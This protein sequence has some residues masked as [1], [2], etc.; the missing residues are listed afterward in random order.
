MAFEIRDATPDD[1]RA[2]R[3]IARASWH[4]AYDD[5]LGEE[6]V[7][8]VVDDWYGVEGLRE[9]ISRDDARFLVADADAPVGFAQAVRDDDGP[10]W[11]PRIYV[12]PGRWGERIGS[13]MLAE[14]ESWLRGGDQERLRLAVIAD[15]EVGNA[16]YEK[17]GYEVVSETDEELFG[18][19]FEEYVR[20][21]E[22]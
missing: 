1:A 4:A 5:I 18:V 16:F 9:S 21:K 3:R 8:S 7:D 6:A 11:F 12:H 17:R 22:L 19:E 2:I 10:A 13:E 14:I 20:E 15:N